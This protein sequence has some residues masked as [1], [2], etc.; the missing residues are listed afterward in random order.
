MA[1]YDSI[2]AQ[3]DAT[4]GYPAGI[5][6]QVGRGLRELVAARGFSDPR[7]LEIGAGSGRVGL[8]LVA[9]G[10]RYVAVDESQA[11]L[12]LF[13]THLRER[14]A[15]HTSLVRADA[16][17]LPFAAASFEV[18]LAVHVFHL[19]GDWQPAADELRRVVR[20]GGLLLLGFDIEELGTPFA[21]AVAVWGELLDAAGVP[22]RPWGRESVGNAVV[23]YLTHQGASVERLALLSWETQPTVARMLHD[24]QY[25]GFLRTRT[26]PVADLARH[27]ARW[28]DWLIARYGSLDA[29]LTQRQH[30]EVYVLTLP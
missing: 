23:D 30:F 27:I 11:M 10:V 5:Q 26:L 17:T 24:Q 7:Y 16:K 3:Y 4:S 19:V 6:E 28:R 1:L 20:R 15:A 29:T 22:R 25:G 13:A 21:E 2:A 8:P 18:G 14:N 12:E 9:A